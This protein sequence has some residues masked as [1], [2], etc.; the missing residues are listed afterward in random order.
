MEELTKKELILRLIQ[1]NLV[2]LKLVS[3]LNAL[4]LIADDYYLN[5]GDTVFKLMGFEASAQSDLLFERVFMTISET[6]SRIDFS[7]SKDEIVR[8]SMKIYD[9]LIFA[10]GICDET[11][12][13]E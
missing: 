12:A 7:Y 4:G 9:E 11:P 8:L 3:G 13:Q 10:K 2:N 1:D 5:L 6:V